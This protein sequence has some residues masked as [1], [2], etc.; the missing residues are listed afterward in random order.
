MMFTMRRIELLDA[1]RFGL[2]IEL[3]ILNHYTRSIGF[4]II[5]CIVLLFMKK[6]N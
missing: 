2:D 5:S 6:S 3:D 4:Y 1:L